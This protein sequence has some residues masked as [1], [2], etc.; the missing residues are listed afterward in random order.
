MNKN[1]ALLIVALL[2]T[3][4]VSAQR[5]PAKGFAVMKRGF[6]FS[7]YEFTRREVGD[8]D[9]EVKIMYAAICHSDLHE[10]NEDWYEGHFP[11][12]PGHENV[13]KVVRV[14]KN[15]TRFKVGDYAG[16]GPSVNA[17]RK[18]AQCLAGRD[19]Y[20]EKMISCYNSVD[21]YHGDEITQGDL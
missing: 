10:A 3:I 8:N 6:D 14:G 21:Y 19:N 1:V 4:D 13:G 20:C 2:V 11:F 9:I 7:E 16:V 15:V 18:C 17:C 5:I 12:V